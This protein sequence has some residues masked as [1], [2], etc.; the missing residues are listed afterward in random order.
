MKVPDWF[1][2]I[3]SVKH[4]ILCR[5]TCVVNGHIQ[6]ESTLLMNEEETC[7]VIRQITYKDNGEVSFDDEVYLDSELLRKLLPDLLAAYAIMV[8][9]ERGE[10]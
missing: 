4:D 6:D 9:K 10:L 8:E 3:F 7:A 2:K 5:H 1:K